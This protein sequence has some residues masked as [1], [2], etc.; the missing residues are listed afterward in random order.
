MSHSYM[1]HRILPQ[2]DGYANLIIPD[3]VQHT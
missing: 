3:I 1:P 2:S